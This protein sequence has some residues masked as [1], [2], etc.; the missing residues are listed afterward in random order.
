ML[1]KMK[2]SHFFLEK[3]ENYVI[4]ILATNKDYYS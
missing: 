2:K 4:I 1:W 3:M